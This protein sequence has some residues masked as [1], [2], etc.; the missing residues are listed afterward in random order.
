MRKVSLLLVAGSIVLAGCASQAPPNRQATPED[1][2]FVQNRGGVTL[3]RDLPDGLAVRMPD[4]VPALDWSAVVQATTEDRVT[5]V[6]A[7]DT[8][9]G[10]ELWS[11]DVGGTFAAKVASPNGT[12]VALGPPNMAIYGRAMTP[13]VVLRGDGSDPLTFQLKGNFEP[14]AFSTDEQSLFVIQYL[15][16]RRPDSYRVRRLDLATGKVVGVYTPDEE[17]QEAMQG[18]GRIQA[19]SP[20]GT[21]LYTLYSYVAGNGE[22]HAFIHVLALDELW[23]HCIDLPASFADAPERAIA[24]AVS[25]DNRRLYVADASADALA[26]IDTGTL[27]IARSA[28]VDFGVSGFPAQAVRGSDGK[29]YLS[30]GTRLL[31]VDATNLT[32]GRSWY[33]LDK[34]TGLQSSS[35]GSHLYVGLKDQIVIIDTATGQEMGTLTPADLGRIG[36]FGQSTRL[37]GLE[38]PSDFTCAC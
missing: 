9:S 12:S 33:M 14:E 22:A 16:P 37:P 23:A 10:Q 3:V 25:P 1:V 13:L 38:P 6:A 11:Q 26:E 7:M 4:A 2:L 19:A 21:R 29:L 20:D 5:H 32:P 36:Q 24:L 30:S 8:A 31:A 34:I 18:T 15:P 35:D 28:D 17:L 27:A